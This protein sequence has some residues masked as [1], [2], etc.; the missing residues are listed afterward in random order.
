MTDVKAN[1]MVERY[2]EGVTVSRLVLWLEPGVSSP[3]AHSYLYTV[4]HEVY[5]P[6]KPC[7]EVPVSESQHTSM[8]PSQDPQVE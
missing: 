7:E 6:T 3:A 4:L 2:G 8:Q 5:R 1:F